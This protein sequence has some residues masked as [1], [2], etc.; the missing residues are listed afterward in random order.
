MVED[1]FILMIAGPGWEAVAGW[2]ASGGATPGPG[3]TTAPGPSPAGPAA[4]A[5][6]CPTT[7]GSVHIQGVP[8]KY[9]SVIR[10][11]AAYGFQCRAL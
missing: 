9:R 1:D 2:A 7:A 11:L 10:L 8:Y 5:P 3:W 6:A 4:A